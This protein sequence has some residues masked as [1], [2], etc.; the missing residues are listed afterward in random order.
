VRWLVAEVLPWKEVAEVGVVVEGTEDAAARYF[1]SSFR[2]STSPAP[3]L[4]PLPLLLL[5]VWVSPQLA[6]SPSLPQPTHRNSP[7]LK[8]ISPR[9]HQKFSLLN[10]SILVEDSSSRR[11]ES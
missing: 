9:I 3:V 8:S 10:R 11:G 1:S 2:I 4:T 6:L 5:L 7:P